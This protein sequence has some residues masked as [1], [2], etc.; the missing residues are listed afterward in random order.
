MRGGISKASKSDPTGICGG[1]AVACFFQN[2]DFGPCVMNDKVQRERPR[3]E[4]GRYFEA[5][6]SVARDKTKVRL[7]S[8][9]VRATVSE[10]AED[11]ERTVRAA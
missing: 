5:V 10:E 1:S 3:K 8:H 7:R 6:R 9:D 4:P 2:L 11:D